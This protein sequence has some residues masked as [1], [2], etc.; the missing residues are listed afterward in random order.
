MLEI[1]VQPKPE[2]YFCALSNRILLQS[3]P[4]LQS[5]NTGPIGAKYDALS[6]MTGLVFLVAGYQVANNRGIFPPLI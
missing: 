6:M 4:P 2:N 5:A 1:G 3:A